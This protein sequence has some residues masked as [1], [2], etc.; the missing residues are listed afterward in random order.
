MRHD[1]SG[2]GWREIQFRSLFNPGFA[3]AFPCDSNGQVD[4]DSLS[5]RA[6][7]N[8]LYAR[9]MVGREFAYPFV[10][11]MTDRESAGAQSLWTCV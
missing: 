9:A 7:S 1:C 10:G 5:E 11:P 6:R 8:Y 2:S 4:L 3:F